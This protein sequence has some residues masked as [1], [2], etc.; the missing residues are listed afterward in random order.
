MWP[1]NEAMRDPPHQN[2]GLTTQHTLYCDS[3]WLSSSNVWGINAVPCIET[4]LT[5]CMGNQTLTQF[6]VMHSSKCV[7]IAFACIL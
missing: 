4:K 6:Y 3:R 7:A 5:T 1:G 2:Y